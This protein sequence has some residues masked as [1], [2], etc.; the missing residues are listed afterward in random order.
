MDIIVII[1]GVIALAAGIGG[2][3]MEHTRGKDK[4]LEEKEEQNLKEQQ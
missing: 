1:M 3:I 4:D 2:F